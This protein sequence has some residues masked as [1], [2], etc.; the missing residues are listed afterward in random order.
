MTLL[1]LLIHWR[2][3]NIEVQY[4]SS[5][6]IRDFISDITLKYTGKATVRKEEY[7]VKCNEIILNNEGTLDKKLEDIELDDYDIIELIRSYEMNAGGSYGIDMADMSNESG[8]VQCN[9]SKNAAKW[10]KITKGL[11]VSGICQNQYCEAYNKEI[12]CK[13]GMKRF[14]LVENADEIRCPMCNREIEPIT[15]TFC[16][17]EKKMERKKKENGETKNVRTDWK[18]VEKDY[19]YYEPSKSG[20]VRWLMLIIETRPL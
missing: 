16:K 17:C 5:C 3:R 6:K 11:N 14:N 18:R 20:I 1:T 4:D 9:Y 10:N 15:C 12:D 7:I 2:E 13:I 19:E 8:L